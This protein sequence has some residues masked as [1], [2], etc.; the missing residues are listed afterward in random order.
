MSRGHDRHSREPASGVSVSRGV[1]EDH[2]TRDVE[3]A[4]AVRVR[5]FWGQCSSSTVG[6][7]TA[8]ASTR[9]KLPSGSSSVA[10]P[11][12]CGSVTR[13][14]VSIATPRWL[15]GRSRNRAAAVEGSGLGPPDGR[16]EWLRY[17]R[18]VTIGE[19][20]LAGAIG[21]PGR[22]CRTNRRSRRAAVP[23]AAGGT[24]RRGSRTSARGRPR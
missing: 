24:R 1:P 4:T 18:S 22:P 23:R 11:L 20:G 8:T 5:S 19:R 2:S 9:R 7:T 12:A 16:R 15:V 14:A 17:C 6:T 10:D 21:S 13:V 3:R